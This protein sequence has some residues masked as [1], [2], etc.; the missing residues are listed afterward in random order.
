[1]FLPEEDGY[2]LLCIVVY[3]SWV[4]LNC[5]VVAYQFDWL[6]TVP[7]WAPARKMRCGGDSARDHALE[8]GD[9]QTMTVLEYFW[10][11]LS[12]S[13][14]L[15]SSIVSWSVVT[16]CWLVVV[17][18]SA[19]R[20]LLLVSCHPWLVSCRLSSS[21]VGQSSSVISQSSSVISQSL[22]GTHYVDIVE[23]DGDRGFEGD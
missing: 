11:T 5:Y 7:M 14:R 8:T 6:P 16:C 13:C 10:D 1:M 12:V 19:S 3:D 21:M 23:H 20:C 22:S 4:N 2:V 17:R 18:P 9:G 15:S